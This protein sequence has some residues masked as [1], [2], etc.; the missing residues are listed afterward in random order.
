MQR[1]SPNFCVCV[2]QTA[3][4]AKRLEG[5]DAALC[6]VDQD[7]QVRSKEVVYRA[8][9][10]LGYVAGIRD[11]TDGARLTRMQECR[12][13]WKE[14]RRNHGMI[15]YRKAENFRADAD[16]KVLPHVKFVS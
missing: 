15:M 5:A 4:K 8:I 10:L 7:S 1:P 14:N 3:R 2:F 12:W 13:E 6:T 16:I 11:E 9:L